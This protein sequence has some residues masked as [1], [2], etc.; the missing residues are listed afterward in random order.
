MLPEN[1][2]KARKLGSLEGLKATRLMPQAPILQLYGA[3]NDAAVHHD[4]RLGAGDPG[5][6]VLV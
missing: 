6:R 3:G 1:A 5:Q 2:Q 4:V